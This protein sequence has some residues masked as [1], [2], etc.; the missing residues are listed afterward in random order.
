LKKPITK[1]GWWSGSRHRPWVQIS[2]AQK[3]RRERGSGRKER[4]RKK[5]RKENPLFHLLSL[6]VLS[7]DFCYPVLGSWGN[8]N[9]SS[10]CDFLLHSVHTQIYLYICFLYPFKVGSAG[11]EGVAQVLHCSLASIRPWVQTLLPQRK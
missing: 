8:Q 2:V 3:K 7:P 11:A 10:L 4:R 1:Q 9:R 5:E 6:P